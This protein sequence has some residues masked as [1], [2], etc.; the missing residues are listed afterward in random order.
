MH[1][2]STLIEFVFSHFIYDFLPELQNSSYLFPWPVFFCFIFIF[3]SF[4][5]F[6]CLFYKKKQCEFSA[7]LEFNRLLK[8]VDTA[9]QTKKESKKNDLLSIKKELKCSHKRSRKRSDNN[10]KFA[11]AVVR[12]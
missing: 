4:F 9:Q 8:Y 6:L 1:K 2:H 11:N 5:S 3:I 7:N 10:F 12:T